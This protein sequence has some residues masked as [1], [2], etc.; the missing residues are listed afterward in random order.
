MPNYVWTINC[1][2]FDS[3]FDRTNEK[4]EMFLDVWMSHGD[5][6]AKLPPHFKIIGKT[7]NAPIAGMAHEEH[8]WFGLQF[9]PEVTQTQQGLK[10]LERFVVDICQANEF[11]VGLY[12]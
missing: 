6:V 7:K 4:G 8:S 5:H 10:I 1:T 12:Y 11:A 9:H 3:I 2:L